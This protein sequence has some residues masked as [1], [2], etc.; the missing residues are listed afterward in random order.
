MFIKIWIYY[1]VDWDTS[2]II[3]WSEKEHQDCMHKLNIW[4]TS[5][6][7]WNVTLFDSE[8]NFFSF[9]H[10]C[11]SSSSLSYTPNPLFH[12][13]PWLRPCSQKRV[14]NGG[15]RSD[16][17][18]RATQTGM[19]GGNIVEPVHAVQI[20]PMNYWIRYS[21]LWRIKMLLYTIRQHAYTILDK[22]CISTA[23]TQR[24]CLYPLWAFL[25]LFFYCTACFCI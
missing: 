23:M 15:S 4:F 13:T 5:T 25:C 2:L 10:Y 9:L 21:I 3:L 24:C 7:S 17:R 19:L 14:W 16:Q 8:P 18:I 12:Q 6:K 20:Q 11:F 1:K 22:L